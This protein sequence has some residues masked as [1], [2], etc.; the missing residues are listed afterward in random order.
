MT[1]LLTKRDEPISEKFGTFPQER[2]ID[3]L[4]DTGMIL[5]DKCSGPTSH[6]EVEHVKKVLGLQKAGHSGTLDPKVTGLLLMGLGRATRL[7]EYMLKSNK[8]YICLMYLHSCVTKSQL[9]EAVKKFTG[10]ILQ[11]PPI[12]SAVKRQER[13]R[14]I[15][16]LE[17]LD[18]DKEI[19]YVLMRI[20]CQHGTYMRKLCTD[21]ASSMG[22]K[23]QMVELRRTKAGPFEEK[24]DSLISVDK[25][26]SLYELFLEAK[27]EENEPQKLL[28]EKELKKY[29]RPMEESLREFK[30]VYVSTSA[31][32]TLCRGS[33]LA[34]PG[35][36][37]LEEDIEMGEE[38][39]LMTLKGELIGMGTA[40][41]SSKEVMKKK[42]GAFVS[43]SKVFMKPGTYP[44]F[45]DFHPD[46]QK[47][48]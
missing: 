34:I 2:T 37:H 16:E 6:T 12:I 45:W 35:V 20:R 10:T 24:E 30:K 22:V 11:T 21:M 48:E 40:Y 27:K 4:L 43:I 18:T 39:A 26:R 14:T 15:Y 17:I 38:V 41:L 23:G 8:E 33:D 31:V 1:N 7:M 13:P 46:N 42:K 25:L 47:E 28:F 19:K 5:I 9:N 44:R 32:D 29:L 36:I 3:Q